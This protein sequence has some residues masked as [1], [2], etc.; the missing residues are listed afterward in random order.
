MSRAA[1]DVQDTYYDLLGVARNATSQE[2]ASAFRDRARTAHPDKGGDPAVFLRLKHAREVLCDAQKRAAYDAEIASGRSASDELQMQQQPR[3]PDSV[4]AM[5]ISLADAV[6]GATRSLNVNRR[7]PCSTCGGSGMRADL[8]PQQRANA[9]QPCGVCR[10]ARIGPMGPCSAC[11]MS[12]VQLAPSAQ[13]ASCSG[14]RLKH[15]HATVPF[16]LPRGCADGARIRLRGQAGAQPGQ[17]AGDIVIQVRVQP[18]DGFEVLHAHLITDVQ[19]TLLEAIAGGERA[20]RHPDGGVKR[21]RFDGGVQP[22]SFIV[23]PGLGLNEFASLALR[24]AVSIPRLSSSGQARDD[25]ARALS[26]CS[27]V[28]ARTASASGGDGERP[29]PIIAAAALPAG[30]AFVDRHALMTEADFVER[31]RADEQL[32]ADEDDAHAHAGMPPGGVQCAQS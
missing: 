22:G 21:L 15:E 23:F 7:V 29:S 19:L 30:A 31:A 17:R 5:Q 1:E 14:R 20:L 8:T 6:R 2:I 24:V 18:S 4:V 3:A 12:G 10:G 16:E 25:L 11:G 26:S 9:H 28:A 32:H 13:C 27:E